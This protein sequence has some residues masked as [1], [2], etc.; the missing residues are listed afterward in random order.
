MYKIHIDFQNIQ[1]IAYIQ[2]LFVIIVYL[3]FIF[4]M[5]MVINFICNII[6]ICIRNTTW[7]SLH[8]LAWFLLCILLRMFATLFI[9]DTSRH[10]LILVWVDIMTLWFVPWFFQY[11]LVFDFIILRYS[12]LTTSFLSLLNFPSVF[13]VFL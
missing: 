9:T 2:F 5:I 7:L 1:L 8:S 3:S 12:A 4:N 6:M 13:L 11:Q 10:G